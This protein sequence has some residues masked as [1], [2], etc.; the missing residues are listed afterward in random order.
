MPWN[1]SG[2]AQV[3]DGVTTGTSIWA[4]E[5]AA[6]FIVTA[7]HFDTFSADICGMLQNCFTI[8][9]QV[10][11][12]NFKL[13]AT[14]DSTH[15]V[16]NIGA[17][18]FANMIGTGNCFVGGAGNFTLTGVQ[19]VAI[20]SG[21][22]LALT[23]ASS[24]IVFG[25]QAAAALTTSSVNVI[26]GQNSATLLSTGSGGNVIIG[27]TAGADITSG[28]QNVIVGFSATGTSNV[29]SGIQNIIV[30]TSCQA[31]GVA[32]ANGRMSIGNIIYG[33]ANTGTG[34]TPS[35]GRVAIGTTTDDGVNKFQVAGSVAIG[36]AGFGFRAKEGANCKQGTT[37]L[38]GGSSVVA[39]TSVTANSRIFL[40]SQVDGGAPG[41][42]RV[43]TR[44][45]ATSF[46]VTSSSGTDT[47]TVAYELFEPA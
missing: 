5:K 13:V 20:G 8:D 32:T 35:S 22:L 15:G 6:S 7:A 17:V 23:N 3:T 30:G 37:V 27:A 10:V 11:G 40:T 45:N 9:G 1:G 33:F 16:I 12:N 41:F 24:N 19:N 31:P 14:T 39:N 18:N 26:I 42:L 2:T 46:T 38:V 34:V 47:S 36:T 29:S 28:G 21:S 4:A 25:Y 44:V 43:S